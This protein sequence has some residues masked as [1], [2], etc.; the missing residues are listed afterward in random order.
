MCRFHFVDFISGKYF[1]KWTQKKSLSVLYSLE[2]SFAEF[3]FTLVI[4][5]YRPTILY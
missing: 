1:E 3:R 5:Y 2:L 4:I